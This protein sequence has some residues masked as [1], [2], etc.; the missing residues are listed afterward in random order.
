[1]TMQEDLLED[2]AKDKFKRI[3]NPDTINW[4]TTSD[5]MRKL[6]RYEAKD[7]LEFLQ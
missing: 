6:K 4:E 3:S 2:F 1:M 5:L 7:D